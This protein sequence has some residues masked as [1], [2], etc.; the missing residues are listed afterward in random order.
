MDTR[1]EGDTRTGTGAARKG[2][3]AYERASDYQFNMTT[4]SPRTR[5]QSL[6][7]HMLRNG[8]LPRRGGLCLRQDDRDDTIT[9]GYLGMLLIDPVR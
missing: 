8:E 9:V 4:S 6:A 3:V 5:E 7:S 1:I 2:S